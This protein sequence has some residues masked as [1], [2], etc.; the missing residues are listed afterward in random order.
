[1]DGR[2]TVRKKK[3]D[4]MKVK[5]AIE[6]NAP[7]EK[8]WPFFVEPAKVLQWC[9]TFKRFEYTT[10][11]RSGVGAPLLHRGRCRDWPDEDAV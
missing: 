7:P 10:D 3:G 5:K 1:M 9:V 4:K 8:I 2:T 11:Q 6:V